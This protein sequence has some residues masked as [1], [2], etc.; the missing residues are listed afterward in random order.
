MNGTVGKHCYN[1]SLPQQH[2]IDPVGDFLSIRRVIP[3]ENF[4]IEADEC[5]LPNGDEFF[6]VEVEVDAKNAENVKSKI[7]QLL[8]NLNI[9]FQESKISKLKRL[10]SSNGPH[11]STSIQFLVDK[12]KSQ[13]RLT[14]TSKYDQYV[15]GE[16]LMQPVN[17]H[18]YA[19][20]SCNN[21]DSSKHIIK[22][23]NRKPESENEADIA[24]SLS[25]PF[26]IK[27]TLLND[28]YG[29]LSGLVAIEMPR[30]TQG[31]L[32]DLI[33]KGQ[34]YGEDVWARFFYEVGQAIDYLHQLGIIHHDIKPENI[35]IKD[36]SLNYIDPMLIDFGL[37]LRTNPDNPFSNQRVGTLN[38]AAPEVILGDYHTFSCDMWSLGVTMFTAIK[39]IYPFQITNPPNIED[40]VLKPESLDGLSEELQDLLISLL[41]ID[42][43]Q[44]LSSSDFLG[45][46]WFQQYYP[47]E[48]RSESAHEVKVLNTTVYND[49]FFDDNSIY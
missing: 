18:I 41:Q 3:W 39:K 10:F 31:D 21:E 14:L 38:Y 6:E 36:S 15:L 22:I 24:V 5:H 28:P 26:I 37:S 20:Y 29:F 16:E 47:L 8:H 12:D 49:E 19:A 48:K 11:C 25:H 1:L 4:F 33:L 27:S 9:E 44:R 45:H 7:S 13:L 32:L 40:Y 46:F 35:L 42:P 30:H 43:Y 17:G 2:G 34:T 23:M